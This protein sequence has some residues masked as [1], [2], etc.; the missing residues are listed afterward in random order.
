MHHVAQEYWKLKQIETL[1][2]FLTDVTYT[3]PP[4]DALLEQAAACLDLVTASRLKR[5]SR[6]L[7]TDDLELAVLCSYVKTTTRKKHYPEIAHLLTALAAMD[8]KHRATYDP[9]TI[10]KKMR[11]FEEKFGGS[12]VAKLSANGQ[13]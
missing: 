2:P 3:G 6:H 13:K 9:A 10:S 4:L 7:L 8:G 12:W 5:K 11:R 1:R